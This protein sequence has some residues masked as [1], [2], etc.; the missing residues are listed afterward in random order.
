[1]VGMNDSNSQPM[2]MR[3][4]GPRKH[5]L[6]TDGEIVDTLFFFLLIRIF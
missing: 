6:P 4:V 5:Q 3:S 2:G 1:M